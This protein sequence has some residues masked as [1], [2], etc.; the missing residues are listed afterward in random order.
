MTSVKR[1]LIPTSFKPQELNKSKGIFDD[2]AVRKNLATREGTVEKVPKNDSDITNKKYVTDATAMFGG[3]NPGIYDYV[4]HTYTGFLMTSATYKTGGAGG[5]TVA[6]V[7][8]TYN[9][10]NLIESITTTKDS[11]VTVE[12]YAY[13]LKGNGQILTMTKT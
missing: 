5:T 11:V 10:N 13:T 8:L 3:V 2:Y 1:Q 12:N 9:S 4:S 6:E 7:V